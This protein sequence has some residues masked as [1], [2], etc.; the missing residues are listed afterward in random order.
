MRSCIYEGYTEHR[1]F[2]PAEHHFRYPLYFYCFDLNELDDLEKTLP[3]FGYNR[4]R[5]TSLY[6]R[7]YLNQEDGTIRDKLLQIIEEKVDVSLIT[8]ILLITSARYFNYIFNPVS[9]YF[10]MSVRD[11]LVCVVAEVNNTFGE[12]HLYVLNTPAE[13]VQGYHAHY[14]AD[15]AFHVSPFNNMAGQYE[16]LFSEPGKEI[17]VRINL[18]R[19]NEK[20]FEAQL[21][22]ESRPLAPMSHAAMLLKNP[23]VPHLSIPRIFFEAARLSFQKKLHYFDKPAPMSAMT[24]RRNPPGLFQRV[25]MNIVTGLFHKMRG[26]GIRM[27]LPDRKVLLYGDKESSLQG[28]ITV[29]DYR[30]FS[31][32]VLGGD[33]GLGEA[34]VD[35]VWDTKD[36][37]ALFRLFIKNRDVLDNGYPATAWLK[38]R[39]NDI[40]HMMRANTLIG[41]PKNI[42]SHYDLGNDFFRTFLDPSMTY[43]CGIYH[44]ET[45]TL[46]DA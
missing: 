17:D 42:R 34:Y 29:N 43:S 26:G 41:A 39:K 1:R 15:K 8:R 45:A 12:K 28:E 21:W 25:C 24:I 40:M 5:P 33:V 32:V 36:I 3:L 20:I 7:D 14:M 46:E 6:D 11:E 35:G 31:S 22:G 44:S 16:F 37:P 13:G 10:C 38:R 18:Y 2:R 19:N 30:F 23:I 4:F 9:F 27:L